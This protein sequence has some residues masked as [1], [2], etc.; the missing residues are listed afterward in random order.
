MTASIHERFDVV[1][2]SYNNRDTLR[3]CVGGLAG[4]EG[5]SVTV[6]DNASAD[7]SLATIEDL[8]VR[9]V[10]LEQ[11]LG[12]G[13]GCNAGWRQ[14]SAP[15]VLFLNP[16]ARIE[17]DDL[18]RLAKVLEE[19]GGGIAAPR[20]QR[21][22]GTLDWSLRRFPQ[23]RSIYG[24]A[25]F[26]HRFRPSACW[27]DDVIREP[28][29][30]ET[31]HTC[32]WASGACLLVRRDLLEKLG[33]FDETFFMYCEDVDLCRRSWDSGDTVVYTPEAVC[34]HAGGASAPRSELIPVLARSRIRYA[35]KHFDR[36]RALAYRAGV[37]LVG[38]SHVLFA[39]SIRFRLGY[40]RSLVTVVR[41]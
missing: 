21:E 3:R 20:I 8:P 2:V 15:Y 18:H 16:D 14:G 40:A 24:Q 25:L 30:Y 41:G 13:A 38:L 27:V 39:R 35:R 17:L 4:A 1:V 5:I 28:A 33:G 26:A 10:P 6:V 11:N 37:G 31:T 36:R 29:A 12:F 9:G 34:V 22:D 7:G 23:V 32:D 19:T